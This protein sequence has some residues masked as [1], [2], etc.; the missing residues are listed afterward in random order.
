[1]SRHRT[2]GY[3]CGAPTPARVALAG[4]AV[5]LAACA[6]RQ[7]V[8]ETDPRGG[9]ETRRGL[10]AAARADLAD[11]ERAQGDYFARNSTYSFD[12]DAVGF[13]P[14]PRVGVSVLEAS[15]GGFSALAQAG[16]VECAV[17]IGS[18]DPPR[19]YAR[20]GGVVSCR[21]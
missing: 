7:A 3:R 4:L 9:A 19:A 1:V 14:S 16:S 12:L 5:V 21:T 13:T 20:T 15:A 10:E 2:G 6:P 18:A 8:V 11:L 17:F